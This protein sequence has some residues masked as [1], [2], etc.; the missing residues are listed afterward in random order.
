[1]VADASASAAE[2]PAVPPGATHRHYKGG[3]Y[4]FVTDA[5]HS[6]TEEPMAVY[7]SLQDGSYWVRPLAMFN[8]TLADGRRRFQPI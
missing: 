8:E 3:F 1:V 2:H 6:E 7:Q 5:R 4:R